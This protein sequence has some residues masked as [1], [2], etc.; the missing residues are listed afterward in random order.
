MKEIVLRDGTRIPQVGLGTWQITDRDIMK[1]VISQG[2]HYGYRLIDAGA[3]YSNEISIAKA[4]EVSGI[5]RK[6]LFLS[7]KVWNTS[8]GFLE[9]QEACKRSLKKL[10]T[11]YF[12]LYLIHWPASMKLYPN[13][14]ELNAETWRGLEQL[15]KDGLARTIGVCNFKVHHL[16]KLSKTAEIMP[17][18]NQIEC[19][20]G[21]NQENIISFCH[22]NQITVEASSPLGNGKIL[23]NRQLIHIGEKY[24]KSSAQICIRWAIQR[25]LIAI[26]KSVESERLRENIDVFNFIL[27]D[28]DMEV[29]NKI[30]YCGGIGIDSDEVIE[31][32]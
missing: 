19:H 21:Y 24:N 17:F 22:D 3:A 32:G 12:D 28:E 9:A 5:H 7:N 6:E 10:R 25:G 11:D 15:Y 29:I 27:S 23:S 16:K 30:P 18:I 14:E 8:R 26:P 13:W 31:F 20:P 2:F 1:S 4:I